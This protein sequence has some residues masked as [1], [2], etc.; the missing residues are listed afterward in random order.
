MKNVSWTSKTLNEQVDII[1]VAPLELNTIVQANSTLEETILTL[2]QL[3][4]NPPTPNVDYGSSTLSCIL[5][6]LVLVGGFAFYYYYFINGV[7]GG[8]KI[9][10]KKYKF[11]GDE[12]KFSE[13]LIDQE[14]SKQDDYFKFN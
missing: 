4:L 8:K 12:N 7:Y 10:L 14:S 6:S 11:F 9:G 5:A 2:F 13:R 1:T 3:P